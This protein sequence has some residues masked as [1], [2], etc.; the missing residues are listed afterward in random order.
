MIHWSPARNS[1]CRRRPTQ[2]IFKQLPPKVDPFRQARV[3]AG[4]NWPP[5]TNTSLACSLR[6]VIR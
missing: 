5:W 2:P 6:M 3:R 1:V 4:K